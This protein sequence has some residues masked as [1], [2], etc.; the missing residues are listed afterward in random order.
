MVLAWR[1]IDYFQRR[2]DQRSALAD[3]VGLW[4]LSMLRA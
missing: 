2:A 4:G 3:P 1:P